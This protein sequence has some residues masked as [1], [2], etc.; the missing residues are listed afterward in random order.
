VAPIAALAVATTTKSV[1]RD[2]FEMLQI[3]A[4]DPEGNT[5][6]TLRGLEFEWKV[7]NEDNIETGARNILQIVPFKGSQ[8]EVDPLITQ[9]ELQVLP[10]AHAGGR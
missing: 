1:Y 4:T 8:Q 9:M 3:L 10:Y 5:F 7:N 6:S 2:E